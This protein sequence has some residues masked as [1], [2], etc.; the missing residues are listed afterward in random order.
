MYS[1]GKCHRRA[2]AAHQQPAAAGDIAGSGGIERAGDGQV[3]QARQRADGPLGG[4]SLDACAVQPQIHGNGSGLGAR[5]PP[6]HWKNLGPQRFSG[7]RYRDGAETRLDRQP[8][9]DSF[10]RRSIPEI[11]AQN[12]LGVER[13]IV[14]NRNSAGRIERQIVAHPLE[15]GR[16]RSLTAGFAARFERLFH[17]LHRRIADCQPGD[18]ARR[19]QIAVQQR[20]RKRKDVAVVVEPVARIVHRQQRA[21]VHIQLED[22]ADGVAVFRAVQPVDCRMPGIRV[23]RGFGIQRGFQPLAE[24]GGGRDVG[25]R[26][27]RRRHLTALEL[28]EHFLQQFGVIAN[29]GGIQPLQTSRR[30]SGVGCCGRRHS[31]AGTGPRGRWLAPGARAHPP[32]R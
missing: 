14:P 3:G 12:V 15:S 18:L 1:L 24:S 2:P 7:K 9:L 20:R 6:G 4:G 26:Q 13:E 25:P 22:V 17:R 19:R 27:A 11:G 23:R 16:D 32:F 31:I 21:G 5:A 8:H 28:S 30:L 29:T 10:A